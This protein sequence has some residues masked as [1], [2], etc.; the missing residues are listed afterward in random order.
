MN[1]EAI[2]SR[3]MNDIDMYKDLLFMDDDVY[4]FIDKCAEYIAKVCPDKLSSNRIEKIT[5]A[6]WNRIKWGWD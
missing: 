5:L 4:C 2:I 1:D 3:I 6:M